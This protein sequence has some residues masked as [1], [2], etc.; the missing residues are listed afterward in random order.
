MT[1]VAGNDY[2]QRILLPSGD[3]ASELSELKNSAEVLFP[4]LDNN[5]KNELVSLYKPYDYASRRA[6]AKAKEEADKRAKSSQQANKS[7]SVALDLPNID[8]QEGELLTL[9]TDSARLSLKAVITQEGRFALLQRKDHQDGSVGLLKLQEGDTFDGFT[10]TSLNHTS[11]TLTR[12]D[13]E[14]ELMMYQRNN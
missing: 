13:K 8:D 5:I 9:Y 10:L 2:N 7:K 12:K 6:Q 14:I 3:N 4:L 11:I 1:L